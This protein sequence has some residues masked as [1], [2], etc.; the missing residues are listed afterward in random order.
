MFGRH[1]P[2]FVAQRFV[3]PSQVAPIAVQPKEFLF[4]PQRDVAMVRMVVVEDGVAQNIWIRIARQPDREGWRIY[5]ASGCGFVPT[6]G[7]QQ[8]VDLIRDAILAST[9]EEEVGS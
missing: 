1:V 3:P 6:R 2:S 5:P 8:A 7:V 9:A 4:D